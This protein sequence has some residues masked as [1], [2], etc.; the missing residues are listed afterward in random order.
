[1]NCISGN[2]RVN[3]EASCAGRCREPSGTGTL[4]RRKVRSESGA[5]PVRLGSPDLLDYTSEKPKK[6]TSPSAA[7]AVSIFRGDLKTIPNRAA[8]PDPPAARL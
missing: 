7:D 4:Q 2:I 8:G 1:M 5:L 6:E 3:I